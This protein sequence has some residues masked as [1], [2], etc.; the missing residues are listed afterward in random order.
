MGMDFQPILDSQAAANQ[1]QGLAHRS[2]DLL[3]G[4]LLGH[5]GER[6]HASPGV[7]VRVGVMSYI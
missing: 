2:L 1:F 4:P 6:R 5:P 3:S 7:S